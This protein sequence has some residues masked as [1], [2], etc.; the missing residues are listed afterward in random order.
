MSATTGFHADQATLEIGEER[1]HLIAL[2]LLLEHRLSPLINTMNLK[3][4][5]CQIDT[6][7]RNLHFGR[8]SRSVGYCYRHFGTLMPFLGG[9]TI[10]LAW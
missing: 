2:Q 7:C 1:Q 5:L 9:A 6:N 8:S 4:L 10:P 3:N